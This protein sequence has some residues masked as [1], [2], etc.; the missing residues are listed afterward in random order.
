MKT[1]LAIALAVALSGC[2]TGG[3]AIL[4]NIE[5]CERHYNGVFAAGV[6]GGA[7]FSGSAKIDCYKPVL[8]DPVADLLAPP[9]KP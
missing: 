7:N 2:T 4:K 9:I 5:G 8:A 6:L 1:F 3:Q